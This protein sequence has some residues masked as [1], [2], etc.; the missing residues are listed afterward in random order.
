V[1]EFAELDSHTIDE[2]P[3]VLGEKR[4]S[5]GGE[6]TVEVA[7]P[8][9]TKH[10]DVPEEGWSVVRELNIDKNKLY[11]LVQRGEW[12]VRNGDALYPHYTLTLQ[13]SLLCMC[14]R[15]G[16]GEEFPTRS[17]SGKLSQETF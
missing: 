12:G 2:L 10:K 1:L 5:Q 16:N 15:R 9:S 13:V 8:G 6:C 11:R 3:R 7:P 14:G 17:G 4:G